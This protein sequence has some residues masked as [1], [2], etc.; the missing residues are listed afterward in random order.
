MATLIPSDKRDVVLV[1]A[2]SFEENGSGE[3]FSRVG[4]ASLQ[5]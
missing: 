3:R 5:G 4:E 1:E 2:C